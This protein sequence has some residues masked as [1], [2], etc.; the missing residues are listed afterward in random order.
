MT[1]SNKLV[2]ALA[3]GLLGITQ[4]CAAAGLNSA[5]TQLIV[6]GTQGGPRVTPDRAEPANLLI[7]NKTNYLIDAGYGVIRQLSQVHVGP[8]NIHQIFITHNHDDHNSDWGTLMGLAWT[9]GN[10]KPI[11]VYGPRGT[12]SMRAG[13]LQYFAPNAAA[14]YLEGAH[15]VPPGQVILAHDIQGPGVVYQDDNIKVTAVENCHYHFSKGSPGYG[16]QHSFAYRFQTPDRVI[17]FSGDTGPCGD[18]LADF[19][20]GADLLVH[21]VINVPAVEAAY[22]N[23]PAQGVESSPERNAALMKHMTTEHSTPEEVGRVAAKA[24]VRLLVLSH[25]VSP[26]GGQDDDFYTA[27]VRKSYSGPL[28]IAQDLMRF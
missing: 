4:V 15:N 21:E 28:V 26:G 7:V 9:A 19:A 12:E 5:V 10:T 6:L 25:L 8:T 2:L 23:P 22:R 3:A 11:T 18:V 13:F 24:G 14:H 16:W 20:K 17:V 27:G 1:T